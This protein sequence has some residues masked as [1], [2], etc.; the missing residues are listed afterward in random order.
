MKSLTPAQVDALL[1]KQAA[2]STVYLV[3]AG[4]CGMS[5]LGHLF[6]DLGY[7][8]AGSDLVENEL[9]HQLQ[10]RGAE[11]QNNHSSMR[12]EQ[13]RPFLAVYSSAIQ[14]GNPELMSAQGLQIPTARRGAV[15][16]ALLRRQ[17]GICVAGMHGKTTT[18]ALAAYALEQLG[19]KPSFAIGAEVSQLSPHARFVN[20]PLRDGSGVPPY[21]VVE[22]D[23][24]DGT[25]GG[26]QP[27]H[28]ILLNLDAE[29]LDYFSDL[30]GV[31]SAFQEFGAQVSGRLIYCA[32]DERLASLFDEAPN[33]VSYGFHPQAQYR[34]EGQAEAGQLLTP[35]A[36][37][38]THFK[39]W[40][41]D[42]LLGEFSIALF[43]RQN[44]SNAAAV[45]ALLH[46]LQLQP[47][48][49]ARA[50]RSFRGA[51][52]RQQE[53][54]RD[55]RCQVFDDYGH[56]P[57][58]IRATLRALKEFAPTRLL[59][60]FQPHRFSRTQ[61][62]MAEFAASFEEAHRLWLTEIYPASEPPIPGIDS[63]ALAGAIRRHGQ[64][65]ELVPTLEQLCAS[66][67][68]AIAPGD[69]ILFLGAGDITEAA[70]GFADQ[71]RQEAAATRESLGAELTR[72]LSSASVVRHDEPLAKRT[73]LRVGGRADLY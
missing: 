58:E 13:A 41:H 11:V 56:H 42:S 7:K 17:R 23:E 67:R 69:L 15:L 12:L 40:H 8:V 65:V 70:R 30:E 2:G 6:L 62:L 18:T 47:V 54:Y 68:Q 53:L 33:G 71:L 27:D 35:H 31:C 34:I 57:A 1:K 44:V 46:Q 59:V 5:G 26:F 49:I 66:V 16:A 32:D 36:S 48:E 61:K 73:T 52:R 10:K 20:A 21:F 60:A 43:G 3:G 19:T 38:F 4:G 51:A 29:H 64:H 63:A 22:A 45:I 55:E 14:S 39:L 50:I 28:A 72:R 24:S 37:R 9:T 25:L